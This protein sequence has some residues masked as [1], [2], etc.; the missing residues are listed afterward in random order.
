[1]T[2]RHAR[3]EGVADAFRPRSARNWGELF[4][5]FVG[6]AARMNL[7]RLDLGLQFDMETPQAGLDPNDPAVKAMKEAARQL[8]LSFEVSSAE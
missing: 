4:R 7:H 8:G 2:A 5:C 6:P 1:M 3:L